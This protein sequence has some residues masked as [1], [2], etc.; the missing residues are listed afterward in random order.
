MSG[1]WGSNQKTFSLPV[2]DRAAS[3]TSYHHKPIKN[4]KNI[5]KPF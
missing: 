5:I 2:T 1:M 4:S 3:I